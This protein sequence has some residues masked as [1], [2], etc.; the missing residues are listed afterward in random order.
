MCVSRSTNDATLTNKKKA[1]RS[2][3]VLEVR[4]VLQ[5]IGGFY[6]DGNL[7]CEQ[8]LEYLFRIILEGLEGHNS[9]LKFEPH[10]LYN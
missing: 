2:H 8:L 3:G 5:T 9:K 10:S 4:P 7:V 1:T 6:Y